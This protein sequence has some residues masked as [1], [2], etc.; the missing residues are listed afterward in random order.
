M[1]ESIEAYAGKIG[2]EDALHEQLFQEKKWGVPSLLGT[3]GKAY[4][5]VSPRRR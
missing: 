3:K 5:G 2:D 4:A 1:E